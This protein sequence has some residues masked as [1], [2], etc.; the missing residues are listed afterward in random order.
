MYSAVQNLKVVCAQLADREYMWRRK[1]KKKA[2]VQIETS[3]LMSNSL[4]KFPNFKSERCAL[5]VLLSHNYYFVHFF[6]NFLNFFF[7]L[8]KTKKTT[9]SA[10]LLDTWLTSEKKP[11]KKRDGTGTSKIYQK[12]AKQKK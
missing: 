4:P 6:F 8:Q 12:S 11:E 9:H 7:R 3:M 2:V 1:L 10:N 5:R